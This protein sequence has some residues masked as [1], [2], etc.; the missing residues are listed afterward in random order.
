MSEIIPHAFSYDF[1][2]T[3]GMLKNVAF[4]LNEWRMSF[5]GIEFSEKYRVNPHACS[6]KKGIM[7]IKNENVCESVEYWTINPRA[8]HP[9]IPVVVKKRNE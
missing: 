5:I 7:Q 1:Y 6:S 2:V 9:Q 8:V 4:I 3:F